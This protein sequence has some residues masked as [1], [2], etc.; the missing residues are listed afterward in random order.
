MAARNGA[1]N[2]RTRFACLETVRC[3]VATTVSV[4]TV[5][6]V[7]MVAHAALR[8]VDS[9]TLSIVKGMDSYPPW[10][11]KA[12]SAANR[13]NL[14]F[15]LQA[16]NPSG[17]KDIHFIVFD[18]YVFEIPDYPSL[19][20]MKD[21][22]AFSVPARDFTVKRQGVHKLWSNFSIT[23]PGKL[24]HIANT[25]GAA[26]TFKA[27]VLVY[28]FLAS[29]TR[30]YCWPVLVGWTAAIDSP[31]DGVPCTPEEE[32]SIDIDSLLP[33]SAATAPAPAPIAG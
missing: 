11:S 8:P 23:D 3:M 12:S 9:Y 19:Y 22:A 28:P 24:S 31:S 5:A 18:I 7:V 15:A 13:V 20:G 10:S 33:G 4:L 2:K 32:L 1:G 21:I 25:Y 16:Y 27:M 14:R 29:V 26:G 30:Y 17:R 6:V